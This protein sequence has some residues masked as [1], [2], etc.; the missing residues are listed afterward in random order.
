MKMGTPEASSLRAAAGIAGDV[1]LGLGRRRRHRAWI[2]V[3]AVDGAA[4]QYDALEKAEG[5][6][7]ATDGC[8]DVSERADGDQRD[9]VGIAARLSEQKI[10][11]ISVGGSGTDRSP[12]LLRKVDLL[13]VGTP[14][15]TGI[16]F[17]PEAASSRAANC[18]RN[19]VLPQAVVTPR[20]SS[21]GLC[22]GQC[23]CVSIVDVVADVCVHDHFL[24][25]G[26]CRER[27]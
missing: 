4:H 7:I 8:A 15:T 12:R 18:A 13:C 26:Y 10:D 27:C 1:V 19:A 11:G 21:S 20:I 25:L 2:P 3:T 16:L 14:G 23:Q 5:G 6:R 24:T 17:A 22:S 9:L